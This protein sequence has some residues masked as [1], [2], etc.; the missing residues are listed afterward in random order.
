MIRVEKL[1]KNY[2]Y[3]EAIKN[4]DFAVS[5]GEVVGFLGPN[6]AGKTTTM[7]IIAGC[8][9]ATQGKVLLNGMD[10]QQNAISVKKRIGYLP[11]VPPL[12]PNMTVENYLLF[13]A[14]IK[15]VSNPKLAVQKTIVDLGLHDV[16]TRFIDHLS[17]GYK[18]RVG[19]AQA[20]IHEPDLL[21][22]DEPTSGLDPA[23][24]IEI[25]QL[26]QKLAKGDRT[27][28]LSTHVLSEVEAICERVVIISKGEVVAQDSI[29]KLRNKDHGIQIE[30]NLQS[31]S[32]KDEL[33]QVDGV[34][35]IT[36][37]D[38]KY[39]IE[40]NK[41]VRAAI[42]RVAVAYDLLSLAPSDSLEDIYLRLTK[43]DGE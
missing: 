16:Q 6:G 23:Q 29:S 2:G 33:L 21:I 36:K 28:L 34:I 15:S 20:L 12:Y 27:I 31:P 26:L 25:R 4:I 17:K 13:A 43:E 5:K 22:L 11:E 35:Q 10:I 1:T 41:D 14:Q 42:A 18:Q 8:I 9:G 37:E 3:F 39:N 19:L 32:L 38:N 40:A 24:R 30:V 7:R